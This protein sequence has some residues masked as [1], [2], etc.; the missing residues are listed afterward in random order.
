MKLH[1]LAQTVNFIHRE[2]ILLTKGCKRKNVIIQA[3]SSPPPLTDTTQVFPLTHTT[4]DAM[5]FQGSFA[6]SPDLLLTVCL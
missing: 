6:L 2:I 4:N 5:Q 1:S 3:E